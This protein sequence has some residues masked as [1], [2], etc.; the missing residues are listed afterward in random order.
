M[1]CFKNHCLPLFRAIKVGDI[2]NGMEIMNMSLN[3]KGQMNFTETVLPIKKC[4]S[5]RG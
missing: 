3:G 4:C 5:K 2:E 1:R